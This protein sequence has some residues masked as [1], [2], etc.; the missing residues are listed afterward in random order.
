MYPEWTRN[1]YP[2]VPTSF[3]KSDFALYYLFRLTFILHCMRDNWSRVTP[4]RCIHSKSCHLRVALRQEE[5]TVVLTSTETCKCELGDT[6]A[7]CPSH[8][9]SLESHTLLGLPWYPPRTAQSDREPNSVQESTNLATCATESITGAVAARAA[10]VQCGGP[11][12]WL[13]LRASRQ[14]WTWPWY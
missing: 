11:S 3:A 5:A 9:C 13:F 10:L 2:V 6:A 4:N 7:F 8:M 14:T 12:T 1:I